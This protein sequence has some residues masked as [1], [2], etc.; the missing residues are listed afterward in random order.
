MLS[1]FILLYNLTG[2]FII[3]ILSLFQKIVKLTFLEIILHLTLGS[4]EAQYLPI[5]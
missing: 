2:A 5:S 4:N 3:I 1:V